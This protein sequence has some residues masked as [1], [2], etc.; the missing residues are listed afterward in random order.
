MTIIPYEDYINIIPE[1]TKAFLFL[2]FSYL[3]SDHGITLN[4]EELG[5]KE[6]FFYKAVYA[7][8]ETNG[9]TASSA[10]LA[11]FK[12]PVALYLGSNY[13]EQRKKFYSTHY[14]FLMPYKDIEAYYV[15]TAEEIIK[16]IFQ[17][18]LDGSSSWALDFA[19][20]DDVESFVKKLNRNIVP[21]TNALLQELGNSF[22]K[23]FS[24]DVVNYYDMAARIYVYLKENYKNIKDINPTKT[25]YSELAMFLSMFYYK[26]VP[27]PDGKVNE[28]E[29]ILNYLKEKGIDASKISSEL[30]LYIDPSQLEAIGPQTL[31]QVGEFQ[32]FF[33]SN[34]YK[35]DTTVSKIFKYV[36]TGRAKQSL[37]IP[38]L[39][40][41]LGGLETDIPKIEEIIKEVRE[42]ANDT[43]LSDLYRN[44]MPDVISFIKKVAHIYT[45]LLSKKETLN[46]DYI[47]TEKDIM[48]ASLLIAS[49]DVDTKVRK[50]LTG[51]GIDLDFVLSSLAL[52]DIEK[53]KEELSQTVSD[54]KNGVKFKNLISY[55]WN[56]NKSREQYTVTAIIQNLDDVSKTES[57]LIRRLFRA[58]T[59]KDLSGSFN[60]EMD[61]FI[62][63]KE[64]NRKAELTEALFEN[65]SIDVYNYLK[66]VCNYYIYLR[67]YPL[68]DIDREQL[69]IIFAATNYSDRIYKYMNN[70]GVT[71]GQ[72]ADQFSVYY[73]YYEKDFDIDIIN[74]HFYKY[75]FDRDESE[76]TVYSIF[77]NAFVPALKNSINLRKALFVLGHQPEDFLDIETKIEAFEKEEKE[78]EIKKEQD[79]L[80][81]KCEKNSLGIL[82]EAIIL[83][84]YI[85]ANMDRIQNVSTIN[86]VKELSMLIAILH[87][88]NDEYGKYFNSNG[89]VLEDLINI[90]NLDEESF[91]TLLTGDVDRSLVTEFA[92]YLVD[93]RVTAKTLV[94]SLLSD[95][96]NSSQVLEQL[97]KKNG[98]KYPE[99]KEEV[100][101]KKEKPLTPEQ[102]MEVLTSEEVEVL[103][104]ADFLEVAN[105]GTSISK[106]SEYISDTL[107]QLMF[108]DSI[109]HATEE[110]QKIVGEISYEETLPSTE[111]ISFFDKIMGVEP[112]TVVV[113]KFNPSKLEEVGPQMEIQVTA[114]SKELKGYK[115]LKKYIE[116]YLLKLIQYLTELEMAYERLTSGETN[117]REHEQIKNIEGLDEE[118]VQRMMKRQAELNEYIDSLDQ[119]SAK[120]ILENKIHGFETMITLMKQEL[121]TVNRAIVSHFLVINSLEVSKMAILPLI[122][123]EM[124]IST[125]QETESNS[126]QLTGELVSLLQNVVTKNI[127]GTKENL[128]RL[129]TS[130]IPEETYQA[131][132]SQIASYISY[133][134]TATKLIEEKNDQPTDDEPTTGSGPKF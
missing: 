81:N 80:F 15:I 133:T 59:N 126:L 78:R 77:E 42:N 60:S 58:K 92:D 73:K 127:E 13:S 84:S 47:Q 72:I 102:R 32:K 68:S 95:F 71:S 85:K 4:G 131:L 57:P 50:F 82:N 90:I 36:L 30:E 62:E 108:D 8:S 18:K 125:G 37:T 101:D 104:D 117:R 12:K 5:P 7:Y 96:I 39:F 65:L 83:F 118:T 76:I 40:A 130:S 19:F 88:C 31:V 20:T 111:K 66:M 21:K 23:D 86:D 41:S 53:F 9:M 94:D 38:K 87:R 52:P 51:N 6:D 35:S 107:R 3:A 49:Y 89:I 120:D 98:Y 128:S 28:Q 14:K 44:L 34:T 113:K 69:S 106:H 45:Y 103:D 105:Y 43:A 115:Y 46:M 17:K 55:G 27:S 129:K 109:E 2:F 56:N 63:T 16:N 22:N 119:I 64:K 61:A 79:S 25:D 114:L 97:T 10:S 110:I 11:G 93:P 33:S 91:D 48:T 75:I 100:K 112:K 132:N 122:S 67:D 1:E 121:A 116:A 134:N 70:L 26:G 123:A 54:E 74:N 99:L 124:A 24:I 29:V